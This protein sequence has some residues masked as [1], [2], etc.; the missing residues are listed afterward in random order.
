MDRRTFLRDGLIAAGCF[1]ISAAIGDASPTAPTDK[2]VL[3]RM[4]DQARVDLSDPSEDHTSNA[5]SIKVDGENVTGIDGHSA[6]FVFDN[7][8]K[9]SK[10]VLWETNMSNQKE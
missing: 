9:L 10:I 4:F 7:H 8:H 6:I 5:I 2:E 1:N 3:V